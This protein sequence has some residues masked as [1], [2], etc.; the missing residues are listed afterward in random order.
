LGTNPFSASTEFGA[1]H[2]GQGTIFF[3]KL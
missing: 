2:L 1:V 3:T